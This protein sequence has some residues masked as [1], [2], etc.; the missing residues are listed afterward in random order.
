MRQHA[1]TLDP[2]LRSLIRDLADDVL[3]DTKD[4][5]LQTL[6]SLGMIREEGGKLELTPKGKREHA[7]IMAAGDGPE[8]LKELFRF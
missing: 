3:I 1:S 4:P 7:R 6:K 8:G 2:E 5:G